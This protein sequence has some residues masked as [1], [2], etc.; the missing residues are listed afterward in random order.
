[1][2]N[3]LH[4]FLSD[5]TSFIQ[6]VHESKFDLDSFVI[7]LVFSCN[8]EELQNTQSLLEILLLITTQNNEGIKAAAVLKFLVESQKLLKSSSKSD[9]IISEL[10][11]K[12]CKYMSEASFSN[13]IKEMIIEEFSKASLEFVLLSLRD[14]ILAVMLKMI[15]KNKGFIKNQLGLI[16]PEIL[17]RIDGLSKFHYLEEMTAFCR[18]FDSTCKAVKGTNCREIVFL[19]D[20]II[21][22]AEVYLKHHQTEDL[23]EFSEV[24]NRNKVLFID[25]QIKSIQ[26]L[27]PNNFIGSLLLESKVKLQIAK[28]DESANS[29][30]E[31]LN[32]PSMTDPNSSSANQ[33]ES[34]K[35]ISLVKVD[36]KPYTDDLIE[37]P[38][39]NEK[40]FENFNYK[41]H[42]NARKDHNVKKPE[43]KK[44]KLN[45]EGHE[46][47]NFY[48][49]EK[50]F[51]GKKEKK[52][53][54]YKVKNR[55][56][57]RNEIKVD[58]NETPNT[59]DKKGNLDEVV[60]ESKEIEK[61]ESER[62]EIEKKESERKE[63]ERKESERKESESKEIESK[64]Q[65]EEKNV[66]ITNAP[67]KSN[68]IKIKPK[69]YEDDDSLPQGLN[70][71]KIEA[72]SKS[73]PE[74]ELKN[75][76]NQFIHEKKRL[77]Q[78]SGP[79]IL[80]EL[81]DGLK[82]FER[83]PGFKK[84]LYLEITSCIGDDTNRNEN[85]AFW[86]EIANAA[87]NFIEKHQVEA[88][89]KKFNDGEN[90]GGHTYNRR[91]RGW[92]KK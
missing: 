17:E 52:G 19:S 16:S 51:D 42:H 21:Y 18:L 30:T 56:D 33:P 49:D 37:P 44:K 26:K 72:D 76:V 32:K 10:F 63:N 11:C 54:K 38:V 45:K 73:K 89:K 75:L 85:L 66:A 86:E 6:S 3:P 46:K 15:L 91:G 57:D 81:S 65:S 64:V 20:F 83:F 5:K 35:K 7:G 28:I 70:A 29:S 47:K 84:T 23:T 34:N 79:K 78:Q 9:P 90:N 82:S 4:L 55:E 27:L 58:I 62:K 14:D 80:H 41:D 36:K 12:L 67:I 59:D 48:G 71:E 69:S 2:E 74:Q 60:N 24:F 31:V 1:M 8:Q 53:K 13:P 43:E 77:F 22:R 87:G 92:S 25:N 39:Q 88:I 50:D 40:F 68:Q 61:K